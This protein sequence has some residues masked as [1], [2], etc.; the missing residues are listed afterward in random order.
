MLSTRLTLLQT[1]CLP[2]AFSAYTV[3][4]IFPVSAQNWEDRSQPRQKATEPQSAWF[5]S[6]WPGVPGRECPCL[7][8]RAADSTLLP[9]GGTLIAWSC[10][11]E[12]QPT[13]GVAAGLVSL[14]QGVSG[15][16]VLRKAV[17]F[18]VWCVTS[19]ISHS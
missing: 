8:A 10:S 19:V 4:C 5:P 9:F 7:P 6:S 16:V 12:A 15:H 3:S 18:E 14:Y 2:L 1:L 13:L 17:S 11:R